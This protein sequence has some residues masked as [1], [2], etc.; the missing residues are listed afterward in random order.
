MHWLSFPL[1]RW[2]FVCCSLFTYNRNILKGEVANEYLGS[3]WRSYPI[4]PCIRGLNRI[5]VRDECGLAPGLLNAG[6]FLQIT[7]MSLN[8]GLTEI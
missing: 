6:T 8:T 1:L 4:V 5:N 2:T 3:L 7:V